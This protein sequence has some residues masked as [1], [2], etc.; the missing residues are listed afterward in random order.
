MN[1]PIPIPLPRTF[2]N[3]AKT[4][5]YKFYKLLPGSIVSIYGIKF[6]AVNY[7]MLERSFVTQEY[8]PTDFI[9]LERLL[10]PGCRFIDVGAN[11]GIYSIYASK[12]AYQVFAFEPSSREF[13]LLEKNVKLNNSSSKIHLSNRACSCDGGLWEM[14]IASDYYR[15]ENS[16]G[17]FFYPNTPLK[18]TETVMRTTLD[19]ELG[20]I[21][22]NP[23]DII[24][25]DTD[26]HE[27]EV[28]FG[29]RRLINRGH[30]ILL[31]EFPTEKVTSLLKDWGYT[32][33]RTPKMYNTVFIWTP[34]KN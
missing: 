11:I 14:N 30:P 1:E 3:L 22:L 20:K 9:V 26:G 24:K 18:K 16:L 6:K 23:T 27:Y 29:G 7:R 10:T 15:G 17:E 5:W 13:Q 34:Q 25:I 31:V 8:E 32:G 12:I 4:L 33:S 21:S 28:L 19:R 2:S